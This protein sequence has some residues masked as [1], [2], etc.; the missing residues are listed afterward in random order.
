MM[1]MEGSAV[2]W[3]PESGY[4]LPRSNMV[5][6]L[7]KMPR[8]VCY[9]WLLHSSDLWHITEWEVGQNQVDARH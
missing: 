5:W 9:R 8:W 4:C 2:R 3:W 6:S 1:R 7:S